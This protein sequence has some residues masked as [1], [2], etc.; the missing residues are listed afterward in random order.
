MKLF[1]KKKN[2]KT[3]QGVFESVAVNGQKVTVTAFYLYHDKKSGKSYIEIAAP[4]IVEA[5]HFSDVDI[6]VRLPDKTI[7]VKADYDSA[8]Q[9]KS[10]N[11]EFKIYKFMITKYN[12][13]YG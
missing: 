8:Y 11:K 3:A 6:K 10:Q 1:T 12:E 9:K 2:K 5:L 7:A 4:E 13:Y